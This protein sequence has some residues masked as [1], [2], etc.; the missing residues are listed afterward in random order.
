VIR[1]VPL[2]HHNSNIF[3]DDDAVTDLRPRYPYFHT[4][5]PIRIEELL[6]YSDPAANQRGISYNWSY[7]FSDVLNPLITAGLRLE[8]LHEFPPGN[9]PGED[10]KWRQKDPTH[11]IPLSFS[12][13]ARKE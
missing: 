1:S 3:D 8:F 6:P 11:S 9:D 12:L 10:E 7:S 5:E 2:R 4:A 13:R